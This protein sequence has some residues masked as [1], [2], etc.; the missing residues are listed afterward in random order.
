MVEVS[1]SV[2]QSKSDYDAVMHMPYEVTIFAVIVVWLF[3]RDWRVTIIS[4]VALPLSIIPTFIILSILDYNLN[5]MTL[6]AL[7][8]PSACR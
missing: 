1:N 4:A 7:T 8:R 2:D 5:V 6:L 3:L